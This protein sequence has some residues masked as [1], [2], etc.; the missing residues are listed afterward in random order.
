MLISNPDNAKPVTHLVKLVTPE[1]D[2]PAENVPLVP[3]TLNVSTDNIVNK[4]LDYVTLLLPFVP[5]KD[6]SKLLVLPTVPPVQP[7]PT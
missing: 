7:E 5:E 4:V 6:P 2:L 3:L 1:P